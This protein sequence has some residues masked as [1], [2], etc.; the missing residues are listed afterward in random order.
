[1]PGKSLQH[2]LQRLC[3]ITCKHAKVNVRNKVT[4]QVRG[5]VN[6]QTMGQVSVQVFIQ[7]WESDNE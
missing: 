1:M 2:E 5:P 3:T 4:K 6:R 7:L